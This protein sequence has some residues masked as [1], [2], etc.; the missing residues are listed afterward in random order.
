MCFYCDRQVKGNPQFWWYCNYVCWTC[1]IQCGVKHQI[2]FLQ[3]NNKGG[4][5]CY[6]CNKQMTDVGFKFKTPKKNNI[7]QW[8]TLEKTWE[9]QYKCID[10]I[11]T[12]V[13]P[14]NKIVKQTF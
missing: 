10:G 1:K 13:G 9:N 6:K 4:R 12:Y 8:T 11:K 3:E 2:D 5:I 7:K 14:K